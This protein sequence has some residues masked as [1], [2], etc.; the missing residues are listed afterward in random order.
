[1]K[2]LRVQRTYILLKDSL[3]KL[4]S[5]K[6]FEDIRVNDICNLAMIHRTT[7]YHHFQDKY[8]LLEFCIQDIEQELLKKINRDNYTN[9]RKFYTNLI[10]GLLEY[11]A[12]KKS[13]FQN[14]LK[15]NSENSI[16]EIFMNTC[17][18]HIAFILQKEE[19]QGINHNLDINVMAHFY[20]GGLVSTLVWWLK[21]NSPLSEEEICDTIVKLIFDYPHN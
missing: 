18:N 4:L 13:I 16:A 9:S 3:F 17:V 7:F 6:A 11:I 21:S 12:E 20:A 5:K 2:D 8:E 10:M 15:H 19:Q 14:V 1:M